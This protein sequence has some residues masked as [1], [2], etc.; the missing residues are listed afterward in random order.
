VGN[1]LTVA[2]VTEVWHTR[3]QV[4]EDQNARRGM[5]KMDIG[6]AVVG[7]PHHDMIRQKVH[8][9]ISAVF[10]GFSVPPTPISTH[11]ILLLHIGKKMYIKLDHTDFEEISFE[12][13]HRKALL[14]IYDMSGDTKS[15]VRSITRLV[16]SLVDSSG[17]SDLRA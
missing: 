14:F 16:I 9:I 15:L 4:L 6:G 5:W 3:K 1:Y 17:R 7:T 12:P 2:D 13:L 11:F 10:R 8:V